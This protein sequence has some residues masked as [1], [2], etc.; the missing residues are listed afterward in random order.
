LTRI[1]TRCFGS[2]RAKIY[3]LTDVENVIVSG[4]RTRH[5]GP[6]W[7]IDL[8]M[9]TGEEA[10]TRSYSDHEAVIDLAN[11]WRQRVTDAGVVLEPPPPNRPRRQRPRRRLAKR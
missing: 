5:L 6:L 3:P 4:R 11:R 10:S 9:A 1:E 8:R 2:P 7:S